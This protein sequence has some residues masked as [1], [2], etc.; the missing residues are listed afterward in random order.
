MKLTKSFEQGVCIMAIIATQTDNVP[1]S[2]RTLQNRLQSSMTYSQKILRKL[3]VAGLVK[4]VPGNNGGFTL[5]KSVN[6]IS[7]LDV[8]VALEGEIDSF[9]DTGLFN[10]VFGESN[11]QQSQQAFTS[12]G[13]IVHNMFSVA[14][15]LWQQV[16]SQVSLA[17]IIKRAMACE[18]PVPQV[19]W[20][21]PDSDIND[22][23]K[24]QQKEAIC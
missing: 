2:S 3:V 16:L 7:V 15:G 5:A 9:P 24:Q 12:A 19:D 23:Y 14:D 17:D 4:S 1:V 6:D 10:S 11:D 20:N 13:Q 21:N 18:S 8:V 22:I